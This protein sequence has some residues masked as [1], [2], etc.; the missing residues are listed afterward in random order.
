MTV[1][2]ILVEEP[3]PTLP[4][5]TSCLNRSSMF[6]TGAAAVTAQMRP[7]NDVPPSQL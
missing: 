2:T 1:G 4:T 3:T 5:S 7:G 6:C